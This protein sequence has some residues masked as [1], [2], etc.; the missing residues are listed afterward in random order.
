MFQGASSFNQDIRYVD[1]APYPNCTYGASQS[2]EI[3]YSPWNVTK[4]ATPSSMFQK[5]SSFNADLCAW[6]S[7]LSSTLDFKNMFLD[8]GC[9]FRYATLWNPFAINPPGPFCQSCGPLPQSLMS[10]IDDPVEVPLVPAAMANL[11][12]G[13]VMAWS[14]SAR[15][16]FGREPG[17]IKTYMT[18]IDPTTG[19]STLRNVTGTLDASLSQLG[20]KVV[21]PHSCQSLASMSRNGKAKTR[22][23]LGFF[24]PP[25]RVI[26]RSH[27]SCR[28]HCHAFAFLLKQ[29]HDMFCPGTSILPDGRIV[30]TGGITAP[31]TSIFN[32]ATGTWKKSARMKVG[33][34]Y[35]SQLTLS[36]GR[37]FLL[38]GS[39]SGP[40]G[41]KFA[42]VYSENSL[43]VGLWTLMSG[44]AANG[45][46]LT[47]DVDG[48]VK[49]DNH[50]WLFEAEGGRV[51]HAGPSK[52]MHWLNLAGNGSVTFAGCVSVCE[53]PVTPTETD[54]KSCFVGLFLLHFRGAASGATTTTP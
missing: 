7:K 49:S 13:T 11:L 47:D 39:W 15:Y 3:Q 14:S 22:K 19:A 24:V 37:P 51:F 10:T 42:E 9:P 46:L 28:C 8:S 20:M 38:G 2:N 32:P 45:T 40:R 21:A 17:P 23:S 6:G 12:D 29:G 52:N 18:V 31:E 25:C 44:I 26:S 53:W 30:V 4:V 27:R 41:G 48:I 54:P 1:E 16:S 5:A 50:M 34:G 36:D 33:R 43:G 35:H